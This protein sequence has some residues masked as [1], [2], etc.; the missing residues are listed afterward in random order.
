MPRPDDPPYGE[1]VLQLAGAMKG[2][3]VWE[4]QIKLIGWG[5]G[6][7]N[8]G[9]G[10][11]MMPVRVTGTFDL[12]TRDAVKRFQTALTLPVTGIADATVFQ[13]IDA[14]AGKYPVL[15]HSMRCPCADGKNAGDILCRCEKHPSPGV[16]TGFGNARFADEFLLDGKK[17]PDGTKLDKEQLDVYDKQEYPGMDKAL[18]WAV[19]ALM[20]RATV[21][22][23]RVVAGY[24]CWED[25]YHHYGK[26]R[27]T[28]R[29]GTFHF[30]KTVEF[31]HDGTCAEPPPD[32]PAVC[33]TC[34]DIRK[35]AVEK[36]GFQPRWQ[37]PDRVS[38]GEVSHLAQPPRN[39]Y[40]VMVSTVRRREPHIEEYVKTFRESLLPVYK[41]KIPALSFPLKY[42]A[43]DLLDPL[44]GSAQMYFT[45]NERGPGGLYPIGPSR[46]W[47]PGIHLFRPAG[48]EVYAIADGEIVG[49]RVG[50]AVNAHPYGSANFVL[51]RHKTNDV[52][53]YSLYMHLDAG[54]ADAGSV[55]PWRKKLHSA[56]AAHVEMDYACPL[57]TCQNPGPQSF[58][59]PEKGLAAGDWLPLAGGAAAADPKTVLDKKA[60]DQS[61]VIEVTATAGDRY[62]FLQMNNLDLGRNVAADANVTNAIAN[63]T[64]VGLASPIRVSAGELLGYIGA[65]P[66]DAVLG[67]HGTFLHLEVFGKDQLMT[68]D[69]IET[70]QLASQNDMADRKA[71]VVKLKA[72]HFLDQAPDDVLLQ[73]DF[74]AEIDRQQLAFRSVQLKCRNTWKVDWAA[75]LTASATR[76]QM[77]AVARNAIAADMQA[78][79]WWDAVNGNNRLPASP[80]VW[81]A[82]PIAWIMYLTAKLYPPP[83]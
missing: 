69:G 66:T 11:P 40:A 13:A 1:R 65:A 67:T 31:L 45:N 73:T 61:S 56:T 24:R 48:S 44:R 51:I 41:G 7:D 74:T 12:A 5:S 54:A 4:L 25:N 39:P 9:V 55:V 19:R 8:E 47:H 83:A 50:Q 14:E 79:S 18:L 76:W 52:I 75:A 17:L 82:H 28:H 49:C 43:T 33:A 22:R 77:D 68:G 70:I 23:I 30:G 3:D 32:A 27:W 36:C 62:V 71:A 35:A 37:E 42:N 80:D 57:F 46:M 78:Y 15:V 16:C 72:G 2:R 10:A 53:W 21:D 38:V 6:S 26:R 63:G 20:R 34:E 58:L 64:P 29:M 59:R 81:H 60:P